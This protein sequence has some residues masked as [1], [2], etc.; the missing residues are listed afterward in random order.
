MGEF[1]VKTIKNRVTQ[2]VQKSS[3]S[4][5]QGLN[6]MVYWQKHLLPHRVWGNL[7][8]RNYLS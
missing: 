1:N 4:P 6:I 7:N 2:F 5:F 3:V 8:H